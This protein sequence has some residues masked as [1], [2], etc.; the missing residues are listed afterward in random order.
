MRAMTDQQLHETLLQQSTAYRLSKTNPP[1]K[2][3][4]VNFDLK[5]YPYLWELY[6]DDESEQVVIMKGAQM[7]F[8]TL[9][10]LRTIDRADRL[11]NRGILYLFPTRED[12]TDFSRTRFDRMLQDNPALRDTVHGTD[13]ANVKQ[14][15]NCF[16][17]F[18][19]AKARTGLKSIPVDCVV[20]DEFDE[21]TPEMVALARERLS[22]SDLAHEF[23]L[24]TPTFPEYGI[25]FEY[26]RTD[27]RQW[28]IK[29]RSCARWT[30]LEDEFPGC[31]LE[32]EDRGVIKICT[33]C[34]AE[35]YTIDGEWVP[36]HPSRKR[37]GYYISQLNSPTVDL[38]DLYERWKDP[39]TVMSE[40]Y[41]SNLGQPYA[42]IE[43]SLD[44][45]AIL[46]CCGT[47]PRRLAYEGPSFAGADVGK[48]YIYYTV[49][50]RRSETHR[51]IHAFHVAESFQDVHDLNQRYKVEI[52]VMDAGAETRAVRDFVKTESGWWGC[53]Y[54]AHRKE[55]YL[56]DPKS[57]MVNVNRTE[58]LD[59][60]H[61]IIVAK[62]VELPR[63]DRQFRDLIM[64]QMK[65]LVRILEEDP[66]TG[67]PTAKWRCK[68]VKNDDFRHSFNYSVIAAEQASIETKVQ[69]MRGRTRSRPRSFMSA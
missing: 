21:M 24:S 43:Q 1:L 39:R 4:G 69:R 29:C 38:N 40:F 68:G 3:D 30:C 61:K 55:S 27:M 58:S 28:K 48:K 49:G 7:G 63:P 62:L 13:S 25:H 46:A 54:D 60:S 42:D 20:Y 50:S 47:N 33:H 19:G 9:E 12:V 15:G 52:G 14:I 5:P 56:W 26:L 35:V 66:R 16:L 8:T 34:S 10:V 45:A 67:D 2:V 32:T 37:R 65:N 44:D 53:L 57:R 22:G 41:N 31:L 18:R 17:Y 59:A 6:D 51:R 64:P 11:Y 36:A 23:K